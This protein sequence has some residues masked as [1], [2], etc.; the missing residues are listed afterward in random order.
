MQKD[1]KNQKGLSRRAFL[2]GVG[3]SS[4]GVAAIHGEGLAGK[5][6]AAGM[7]KSDRILGP[8]EF[9]AEAHGQWKIS[10]ND[11]YAGNDPCRC[12]KR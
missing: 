7:L 8:G 10:E 12:S 3:L 11:Y 4:V 1:D 2:K 6:R 9:E 5:L